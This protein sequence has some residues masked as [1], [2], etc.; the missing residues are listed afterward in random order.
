MWL[1]SSSDLAL[2]I[3]LGPMV[4]KTGKGQGHLLGG[5][6]DDTDGEK[7]VGACLLRMEE[8]GKEYSLGFGFNF[9]KNGWD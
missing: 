9:L 5:I 3:Q 7:E 8:T 2:G 6:R 1:A 4:E